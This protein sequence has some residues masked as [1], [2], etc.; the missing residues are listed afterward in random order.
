MA[1]FAPNLDDGEMWLP[2]E[3]IADVGL[4]RLHHSNAAAAR[5]RGR[6]AY[7]QAFDVEGLASQ[8]A[9]LSP[10]D[11]VQLLPAAKLPPVL[12]PHYEVSPRLS[13]SPFSSSALL[14]P[15]TVLV[16]GIEA[17]RTGGPVRT[18][19]KGVGDRVGPPRVWRGV[20]SLFPAG[21]DPAWSDAG[22]SG[23]GMWTG[24]G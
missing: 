16:A 22:S 14:D 6:G 5:G 20:R 13:L 9:A 10:L 11:R 21:S 4:R 24:N 1:E 23:T 3:I 8:L 17:C 2:S 7:H 15:I 19:G 18:G 12:P